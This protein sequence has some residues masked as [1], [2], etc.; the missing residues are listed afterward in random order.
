MNVLFLKL[1]FFILF[2][3]FV[4]AANYYQAIYYEITG[5]D[6]YDKKNYVEAKKCFEKIKDISRIGAIHY[7][8]ICHKFQS[9][10]DY[11]KAFISYQKALELAESFNSTDHTA[12]INLANL[13]KDGLGIGSPNKVQAFKLFGEGYEKLI[14]SKQKQLLDSFLVHYNYNLGDC[15]MYGVGTEI[16]Y[17]LA[18]EYYKK[19]AALADEEAWVQLASLYHNGWGVERD[20][21]KSMMC[22][23]K[24]SEL[25]SIIGKSVYAKFLMGD[26]EDDG[27]K[28]DLQKAEEL[29]NEISTENPNAW[30]HHIELSQLLFYHKEGREAEAFNYAINYWNKLQNNNEA[31]ENKVSALQNILAM[32]SCTL[33]EEVDDSIK[34]QIN[35]LK[36]CLL[37]ILQNEFYNHK[38]E[39][40]YISSIIAFNEK[41]YEKSL[42]LLNRSYCL[43]YDDPFDLFDKLKSHIIGETPKSYTKKQFMKKSSLDNTNKGVNQI[44]YSFINNEVEKDFR[45]LYE[46]SDRKLIEILD[47]MELGNIWETKGPGQPEILSAEKRYNGCIS[48]RLNDED[49][50]IYKII[51]KGKVLVISCKG[52]YNN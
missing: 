2:S 15:Y 22:Y 48:R 28:Q 32:S 47:F 41:K 40:Y 3:T 21:K 44:E 18:L 11:K 34:Q 9:P 45:N 17:K 10:P 50:F 7:A 5:K 37:E 49:R 25:G 27:I 16:N 23:K 51:G 24:A 30:E 43:G 52:H 19:A 12:Y 29:L 39:A 4:S 33:D 20:F 38:K 26:Y 6:Y 35:K 42:D 14:Q 46:Y 31:S 1:S 13:Y 8:L 36:L